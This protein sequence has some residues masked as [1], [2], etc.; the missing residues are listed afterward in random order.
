MREINRVLLQLNRVIEL[1]NSIYPQER[2]LAIILF[3]N[4]VELQL[5]FKA[6]AIFIWDETRWFQSRKL[7]ANKRRKITGHK[8]SEF[9]E[10]TKFSRKNGWI[11]EDEQQALNSSHDYRNVLYHDG[12]LDSDKIDLVILVYYSFLKIKLVRWGRAIFVGQSS[13]QGKI[14]PDEDFIN[15]SSSTDIQNYTLINWQDYYKNSIEVITNKFTQKNNLRVVAKK[16]LMKQI[17]L[18]KNSI[19]FIENEINLFPGVFI[20]YWHLNSQFTGNIKGK[21]GKVNLDVIL[22]I[23]AFVR[24]N[25]D[26][27]DDIP[28][29][30][31]RQNEGKIR[32]DA[33]IKQ[34]KS[35]YPY[36]VN[37]DSLIRRVENLNNTDDLKIF[38]SIIGIE[39]LLSFLQADIESASRDLNGFINHLID[40][41]R[42]K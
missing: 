1:A 17:N 19:K 33:H 22:L 31:A 13:T 42:G 38:K 26:Y 32:L 12:V 14:P 8:I 25:K 23:Y 40:Y 16:L 35:K 18:I 20:R 39:R 30:K 4:L 37:L 5:S 36:W 10:L 29:T 34:N 9:R 11:T 15:F 24:E 27:L 7:E 41:N 28:D 3:D 2:S 21:F 6:K